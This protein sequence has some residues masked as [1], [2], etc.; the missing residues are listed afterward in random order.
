MTDF[1]EKILRTYVELLR[2][3][4]KPEL[5]AIVVDAELVIETDE[6][7]NYREF[8]IGF[9]A[10]YVSTLL[11]DDVILEHLT[12]CAKLLLSGKYYES[13]AIRFGTKFMEPEDDW[14]ELVKS[15]IARSKE[16]NQGL[17]TTIV[18]Q[19]SDLEPLKYNE[20]KFGSATEI[21][22]A[23]ELE[24]RKILFFPLPL[25]VRAETGTNF[26]DHREPDFL[27]CHEGVWGILEVA[28]HKGRYEQDK[29]KDEWFKESGILCV[30]HYTAEECYENTTSVV[31]RFLSILK[32][33][34]K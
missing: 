13:S 5:A 7:G 4:N 8:F 24:R 33:H 17:V 20:M 12:D 6:Y 10:S 16:P 9:P 21:R 2:H 18:R 3:S 11:N 23:Q 1:E 22:V 15:L 29:Q 34:K 32:Q 27:I 30:E 19:R 26:L 25:A 14:R 28:F 31:N